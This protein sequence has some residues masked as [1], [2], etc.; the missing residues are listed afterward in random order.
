LVK[1][2][3]CGRPGHCRRRDPGLLKGT[4]HL[5]EARRFLAFLAAPEGK[6]LLARYG[7]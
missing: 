6:A 5:E 3:A 1:V 7:L 4:K 2:C